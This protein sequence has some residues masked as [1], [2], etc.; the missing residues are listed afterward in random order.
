MLAPETTKRLVDVGAALAG[1]VILS[2]ALALIAALIRLQSPGPAVFRQARVGRYGQ[3]FTCYKFRSMRLG[4]RD[5]PTHEVA[6]DAITP[7]GRVLRRTK[8]DELPQLVNVLRG[9]MSLVGPRP[10]LP[11]QHE[12]IAHRQRHGVLALRPGI[13]GLAQV[14]GVDMSRPRLLARIDGLYAKQQSLALDLW[15]LAA[16]A[17][18]VSLAPRRSSV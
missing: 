12:L 16:T 15:L 9:D 17:I 5:V 1:L 13:T 3:T 11:T 8:L 4:T 2:P 10:C 18:G 7:L 14:S 6:V